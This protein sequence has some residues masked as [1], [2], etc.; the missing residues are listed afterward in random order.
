[1]R[2]VCSNDDVHVS[3]NNELPI[4]ECVC[5]TCC[6]YEEQDTSINCS[7]LHVECISTV[8]SYSV[9]NVN[10]SNGFY[11]ERSLVH[12]GTRLPYALDNRPNKVRIRRFSRR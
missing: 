5:V 4:D 9:G 2:I 3:M 1:M 12:L 7:L 10:R 6:Q 8:L 11:D